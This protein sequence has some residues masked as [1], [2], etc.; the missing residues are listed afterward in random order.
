MILGSVK[1]NLFG[2]AANC[3]NPP[4]NPDCNGGAG[5]SSW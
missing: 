3:A 1:Y 2:G 5:K 4:P